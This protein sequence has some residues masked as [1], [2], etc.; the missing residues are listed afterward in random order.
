[1]L[2]PCR[3]WW[4]RKARRWIPD[5]DRDIFLMPGVMGSRWSWRNTASLRVCT[6]LG[7]YLCILVLVQ[8]AKRITLIGAEQVAAIDVCL[9]TIRLK[10]V[11]AVPK[12]IEIVNKIYPM[13]GACQCQPWI[14]GKESGEIFNSF[15]Q[16]WNGAWYEYMLWLIVTR[17]SS[18][19]QKYFS[20]PQS[21]FSFVECEKVQ[22]KWWASCCVDV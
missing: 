15:P 11:F 19:R 16:G 18:S 12:D 3:M 21:Q 9:Y 20:G 6:V 10:V 17:V 22:H 5:W 7:A 14:Q 4:R 13:V 2:G 8:H 1:M